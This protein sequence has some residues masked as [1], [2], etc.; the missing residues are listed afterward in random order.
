MK[1]KFPLSGRWLL[2]ATVSLLLL[3]ACAQTSAT[4]SSALR[5]QFETI[6]LQQKQQAEQLQILQ[7]QLTE[8]QQANVPS[9]IAQ[10]GQVATGP[11]TQAYAVET[12]KI[13]AYAHTEISDLADSASTYLSAFSNLA[14]GRF[15]PAEAGFDLFL[16]E[17]PEHQY[18]P[19]ARYWLASAQAA[20]G[21]LQAAM[22]N[23]R[24]I[25]VDDSGQ[26]KAPAALI[27]LA[28]LYRQQDHHAEADDVL[29]QLRSRYPNSPEAQHFYQSDEAQ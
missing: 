17:Y 27:Q 11:T 2:T 1:S 19:N 14:A 3:S 28:Q 8:L 24:Q 10:T 7:E 18:T 25:V 5:Q 29:E 16:R 21:N 22:A 6:L 9:A 26:E 20:Q 23:L 12:A 4:P 15:A 13:P